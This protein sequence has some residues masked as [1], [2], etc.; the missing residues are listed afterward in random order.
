MA[1]GAQ[2][3]TTETI[4]V[5]PSELGA[6]LRGLRLC[7]PEAAEQM[8]RSMS[9]LGQLT[10]LQAFR[11][12]GSAQL[13][14]FDGLKRW[15]ASQELSWAK[16]RVE[17]HALDGAGAKVRL[18]LCN[19]TAGLSDLEVAWV[20]RALYREDKVDQP[21][22]AQLLGRDKSWV[23][24]K[25]TLAEGL[26]DELTGHVRLGLVSA[27]AAVELARLHRRNQ[28]E[29]AQ[30]VIRR[31][32][33]KRQTS[34]LVDALLSAPQDQ[35]RKVLEQAASSTDSPKEP[36]LKGGAP[37]RTP[38]EQLVADAWTMKRVAARLHARLLER[39]LQS[40]GAPACATVSR[41]LAELRA[42]LGALSETLDRRLTATGA[43]D[44]AA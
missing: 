28:D 19:A 30:V 1:Q 6:S 21:H 9:R 42:A 20:V 25:L 14:L 5:A 44:A 18:L 43:G 17:V 4:E 41:E 10:A 22:I 3:G 15:R 38:G 39:S 36:G 35:W 32:L 26:S 31:G 29:V 34:R 16:V 2:H 40:L 23:C 27:T 37:R 8:Q 11:V 7:P 33:T 13:E 24:R 12:D